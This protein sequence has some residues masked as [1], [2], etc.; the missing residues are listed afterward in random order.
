MTTTAEKAIITVK[1]TINAPV[2]KVWEFWTD[3]KHIVQW[4]YASDDWHTPKAENDLR[5]GGKF[6]SRMEA[7]DGSVGFDF[8]GE[9]IKIELHK[10]IEYILE[11]ERRVQVLFAPSENGTTLTEM[12]EAEQMNSLELQKSGWQS[13]LD[14]FKK[15]A[16][17]AG[18]FQ[19]LH[20][21]VNI[22]APVEKVY[23]TM[24]AE[25]TYAI[26]T[27]EFNP[28][29]HFEGSW[30][31]GAK[32]QF[33]GTDHHGNIGGMTSR[34]KDNILNKFV[35]IEHLGIIQ[36][37]TEITTGDEVDGWAGATE[38]YTFT[39]KNGI[40]KLSVDLDVKKEFM[41]YFVDTWPGALNK[42]KEICEK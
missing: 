42:L 32:I 39:D 13:I 17:S 7:R 29:S 9:Y 10:T 31:K 21:E 24:I 23:K 12:F 40:T 37:G 8:I 14:N 28:T 38:N 36:N 30:E 1:V 6:L 11:D 25:K 19:A 26:W 16:E 5:V 20:F 4:N 2:E 15:Y 41:K 27:S 22:N 3:P 18:K 34:I 35:S 33:L